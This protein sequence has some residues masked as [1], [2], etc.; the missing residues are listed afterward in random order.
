MTGLPAAGVGVQRA[1]LK[2]ASGTLGDL[3]QHPVACYQ[4]QDE[5]MVAW[6][7]DVVSPGGATQVPV[8][9]ASLF[10]FDSAGRI[11]WLRVYWDPKPF[12]GRPGVVDP[13]LRQGA[14]A[15]FRAFNARDWRAVGR[16]F[17]DGAVFGGTLAGAGLRGEASRR[18]IYD[19]A[20]ARFPGI[21]MEPGV[22][23]QAQEDLAVHWA[24]EAGGQ[25]GR[26]HPIRGLSLF[27]FD[28]QG[29]ITR[30]RI[31]WDPRPLL[32]EP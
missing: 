12:A 1:V 17:A 2:T 19:A 28:A 23:F 32:Q 30:Y 31:Y 18:A 24:G 8:E 21:R 14:E 11:L 9:G 29:R 26:M 15:Y 20:V 3:H 16:L 6:Q 22:A 25:D 7:G 5:V 13:A 27:S 4:A 10:R